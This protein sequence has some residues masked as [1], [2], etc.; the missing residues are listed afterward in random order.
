M[1]LAGACDS[2]DGPTNPSDPTP[3]PLVTET[4]AGTLT[5]NGGQTFNFPA[6]GA[7][8]VVATLT[9]TTPDNAVMGI[10]LGTWTGVCQIVLAN[11]NA[12]RGNGVTAVASSF[13]H[14][15]VRVYDVGQ[16]TSSSTFTVTVIHP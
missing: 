11:D 12:S 3:G 5:V 6:G 14:L 8:E 7:G 16:L 4:F 2:G 1:A 13:G 10:A 15:C 9:A